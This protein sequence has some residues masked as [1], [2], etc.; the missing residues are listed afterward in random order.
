MRLRRNSVFSRFKIIKR[1]FLES[2]KIKLDAVIV[3]MFIVNLI[4]LFMVNYLFYFFL[5]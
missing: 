5:D 2:N 4:R 3:L 1:A